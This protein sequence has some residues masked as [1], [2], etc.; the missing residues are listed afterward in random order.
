MTSFFFVTM[1]GLDP[2]TQRREAP[3]KMI[4]RGGAEAR[5]S[6]L[7]R[8]SASSREV[9]ALRR[10]SARVDARSLGG[11]VKRGHGEFGFGGAGR[12]RAEV[13]V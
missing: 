6:Y 2:A 11:R 5:S 4:S 13:R 7:L 1:A 9:G 10:G 8:V 3:N 12:G